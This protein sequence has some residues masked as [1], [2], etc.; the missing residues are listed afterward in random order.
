[1]VNYLT[2]AEGRDGPGMFGYAQAATPA[3]TPSASGG[4]QRAVLVEL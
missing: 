1:V 2:T 4:N 3:T